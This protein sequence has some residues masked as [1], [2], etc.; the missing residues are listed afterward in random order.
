MRPGVGYEAEAAGAFCF[1]VFHD[2]HVD[3]VAP[4]LKVLLEGVVGGAVVETADEEFS[5]L[6]WFSFA[7]L[8]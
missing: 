3:D 1:R 5:E 4:L 6:F 2:D 8:D 7:V